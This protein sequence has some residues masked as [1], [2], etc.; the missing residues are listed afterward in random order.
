[1]PMTACLSLTPRSVITLFRLSACILR[2]A[3]PMNVSSTSISFPPPPSAI[4]FFSCRARRNERML[5]AIATWAGDLAALIS[6]DEVRNGLADWLEA[7]T[8]GPVTAVQVLVKWLRFRSPTKSSH[9]LR[10]TSGR[11]RI[12]RHHQDGVECFFHT[13]EQTI[14]HR[15]RRTA[16]HRCVAPAAS[17]WRGR[18]ATVVHC[19]G[20]NQH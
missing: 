12:T 16:F 6:A 18:G 20:R 9:L 4:T 2:A 15:P 10:V 19:T 14:R 11:A 1:M 7:F 13:I 5:R 8:L 17:T 3:P